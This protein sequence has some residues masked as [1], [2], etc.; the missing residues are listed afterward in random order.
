MSKELTKEEIL[1]NHE[2]NVHYYGGGRRHVLE[3]MEEYAQQVAKSRAIAFAK[4][5][6]WA[7]LMYHGD[8]FGT[9]EMRDG[10]G[11]PREVTTDQLYEIFSMHPD[12]LKFNQ[13]IQEK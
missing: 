13:S 2:Y 10:L 9:W 3:A 5:I 4:F 8:K 11:F 7:T 1:A 6:G 12:Q